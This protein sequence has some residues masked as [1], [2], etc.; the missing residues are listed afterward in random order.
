MCVIYK[1]CFILKIIETTSQIVILVIVIAVFDVKPCSLVDRYQRSGGT[2]CLHLRSIGRRW[3]ARFVGTRHQIKRSFTSRL[4]TG[5]SEPN[6]LSLA[7]SPLPFLMLIPHRHYQPAYKMP[8][9]VAARL[10]RLGGSIPGGD[11]HFASCLRC[12]LSSGS[13]SHGP[14]SR[15]ED[16]YR[17]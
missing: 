14:I 3:F 4:C 13:H 2:S 10:L 1:A 5:L 15:P 7:V 16:S 9:P 11:M 12:A 8:I 6:V 17:V